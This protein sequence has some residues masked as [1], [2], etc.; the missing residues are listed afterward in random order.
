LR[1]TVAIAIAIAGKVGGRC[2]RSRG[3]TTD[4]NERNWVALFQ[5][6]RKLGND[7]LQATPPAPMMSGTTT[8]STVVLEVVGEASA[9]VVGT[10]YIRDQL[11]SCAK[12]S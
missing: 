5:R 2:Y 10:N 7:L 12:L 11:C 6:I 8:P 4:G 3:S 1:V 9:M